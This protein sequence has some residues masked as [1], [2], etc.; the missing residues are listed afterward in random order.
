MKS[1][2]REELK[3]KLTGR[4]CL[5]GVGNTDLG[6][7]GFGV[8]LAQAVQNSGFEHVIVA[9]T[10]PENWIEKIITQ[11]FD[12]VLFLDAVQLSREPGAVVF[13]D[14]VE[15]KTRFPQISTHKLSLSL[16]AKL[17]QARSKTK[18]WLLGAQ[19]GSLRPSA[20]LTAS[21]QTAVDALNNILGEI[22]KIK[23]DVS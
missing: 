5:V 7:D 20:T 18:V 19:P 4:V 17:I 9:E 13:L 8:R 10:T 16:L 3:S 22:L 2:L 23:V 6:D 11:G 1:D 21:V 12:H 14:A 15:I